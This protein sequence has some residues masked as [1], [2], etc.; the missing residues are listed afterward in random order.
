VAA[1]HS[2][3]L[4]H[5]DVK[6][7]NILL[8]ENVERVTLTDFGLARAVDD[9]A[10]TRVG[11]LAGTPQYMSPEQARGQSV[12]FRSDLFSLGSVLYA[13]CTGRP[14]FRA[15]TSY[16]VLRRI[17]DDEPKAIREMNPEIP[18][19]LCQVIGK[20]MSKRAT[21][22]YEL[23]GE[24]AELLEACLAHVQQPIAAELP[25]SLRPRSRGRHFRFTSHRWSGV[26][27]MVS[28]VGLGLLGIF[29]W[30]VTEAP[31][32][33]GKWSGPEWGE[34]VLTATEPGGYEGTYTDTFKEKPGTIEVKWSRLESRFNGT[35]REGQNRSGKISLRLVDNEIRGAWTTSKESAINP[36]TPELADL[37][38]KRLPAT[39][40]DAA[41][42]RVRVLL[43]PQ[44]HSRE[45]LRK[46][47][48]FDQLSIMGA[49]ITGTV[50]GQTHDNLTAVM[51][52]RCR[53]E[54][55]QEAEYRGKKFWD[56]T[57]FVPQDPTSDGSNLVLS[58]KLLD[59][60]R[61]QGVQFRL[62]HYRDQF[63]SGKSLRLDRPSERDP[64]TGEPDT[65]SLAAA[66]KRFNDDTAK[67]RQDLFAPPIP[68]L[69]VEQLRDGFRQTA[70]L[71][72]RQGKHQIADSLQ[73]IADTGRLPKEARS[74]LIAT[75]VHAQN[76]EGQTISRQVVPGLVLPDNITSTGNLLV[77]LRPLELMYRKD[78]PVSKYYGDQF[79]GE[80]GDRSEATG[81]LP[82][83]QGTVT[84]LKDQEFV[85]ISLGADDGLRTGDTLIVFRD[86]TYLGKITIL[87]VAPDKSVARIDSRKGDIRRGDRVATESQ[88]KA[89]SSRRD[90]KQ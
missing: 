50:N 86:E 26:I 59:H 69:T 51:A 43:S 34:V 24:V 11:T 80:K 61:E 57:L 46:N 81:R 20:L 16:G 78:G 70:D 63:S 74:D 40:A 6:P 23:A 25:A 83:L 76:E 30:Q 72:R 82:E 60:M 4:V 5:R 67:V 21:D 89:S 29:G 3:G 55:F 49:G 48:G 33:V 7:A 68:D 13:V 88:Q 85:E 90:S 71:Y 32:I 56:A 54:S 52:H 15:E 14:P 58:Q 45:M 75:G 87:R 22:R 44:T 19:W 79:E 12:D 84:E 53:L 37:T 65:E 9:V 10:L 1:A 2:Q 35:W 36:G 42:I 28:V 18:V 66:A 31:D 27:A 64:L 47:I 38:W 73:N 39:Q 8:S 62:D 17:T 77:M 41:G